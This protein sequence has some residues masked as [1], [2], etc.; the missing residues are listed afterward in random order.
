[1]ADTSQAE[2]VVSCEHNERPK[3][4]AYLP[5]TKVSQVSSLMMMVAQHMTIVL[6]ICF[7]KQADIDG[8]FELVPPDHRELTCLL[9]EYDHSMWVLIA[10]TN[11]LS[12]VLPPSEYLH[13]TVK[14][15]P[16]EFASKSR[17]HYSIRFYRFLGIQSVSRTKSSS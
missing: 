14:K 10:F 15:T 7:M 6:F 2:Y 4:S 5:R 16:C 17:D 1:M 11:E 9:A 3:A 8:D 12:T 13:H